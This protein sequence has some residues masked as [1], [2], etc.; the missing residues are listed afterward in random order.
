MLVF[1]A[2]VLL[3][4]NHGRIASVKSRKFDAQN[5][6]ETAP[7]PQTAARIISQCASTRIRSYF[8]L[9]KSVQMITFYIVR[10][11]FNMFSAFLAVFG[12]WVRVM[13]GRYDISSPIAVWKARY[14]SL[15]W[16]ARKEWHSRQM[17]AGQ[18]AISYSEYIDVRRL[19]ETEVYPPP[20]QT[21]L[22]SPRIGQYAVNNVSSCNTCIWL[23]DRV[24]HM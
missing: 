3:L 13:R 4:S 12:Q 7:S 6:K 19:G 15:K 14:R 18:F 22:V 17:C 1:E 9:I 21:K 5:L 11:K 24:Y 2:R 8:V 16:K 10:F 23:I 20:P